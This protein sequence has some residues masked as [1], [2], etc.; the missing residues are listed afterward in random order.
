M[1]YMHL[2]SVY[3]VVYLKMKSQCSS[4][5]IRCSSPK[6]DNNQV[7]KQII[8]Q[9]IDKQNELESKIEKKTSDVEEKCKKLTKSV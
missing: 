4:E 8:Q 1:E 3:I 6:I 7:S 2:I 5:N 9:I